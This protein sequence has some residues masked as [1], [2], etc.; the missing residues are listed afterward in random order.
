MLAAR[1]SL[2]VVFAAASLLALDV[3]SRVARADDTDACLAAYD[4]S[5]QLRKDGK[6]AASREQLTLCMQPKC[7]A[8]IKR[9]CSLWMAELEKAEPSV[10]VKARD[11]QGKD[12]PSVRVSVDGAL[13]QERLD[14][15]PHELDPGVHVFRYERDRT[16]IGE[17]RVVV[18]EG[19][20]NRIVEVKIEVDRTASGPPAKSP[21][22]PPAPAGAYV[23]LGVGVAGAAAFGILAASGQHDLDQ[24]RAPG[25]CAPRCDES[26]VSAARTKILA[27]NIS[28]GAGIF[29]A[30]AATYWLLK[31]RRASVGLE[32]GV[33]PV[34]GGAATD[35]AYRF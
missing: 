31:P 6:L 13:F 14:G 12:V 5:Q 1:P 9:D 16:F 23:L 33:R 22:A 27:A 10:I 15:K 25:G 34:A 8:L 18:Q 29:A 24:M 3:G 7:H 11:A 35:L 19:E 30:A 26:E 32:L 17:E 21:E 4:R 20:K 2:R 28:L